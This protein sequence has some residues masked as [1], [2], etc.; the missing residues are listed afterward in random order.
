MITGH[1]EHA[2]ARSAEKYDH[3]KDYV[4]EKYD[5]TKDYAGRKSAEAGDYAGAKK[6]EY[7]SAGKKYWNEKVGQAQKKAEEAKVEL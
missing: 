2:K 1:A 6:G 5:E 7:E 4:G 3:A